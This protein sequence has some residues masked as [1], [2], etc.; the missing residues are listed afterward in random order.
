MATPLHSTP[1]VSALP[2]S[3]MEVDIE[4]PAGEREGDGLIDR[5]PSPVKGTVHTPAWIRLSALATLIVQNS[6]LALTMRYSRVPREAAAVP[7]VGGDVAAAAAAA[8]ARHD[9]APTDVL[10]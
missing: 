7:Y 4:A 5:P 1:S 10:P 3:V 9:C 8:A 6:A 2:R